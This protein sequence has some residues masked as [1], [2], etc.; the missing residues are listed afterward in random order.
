MSSV[1]AVESRYAWCR[2]IA[3]VLLMA[4]GGA[5]MYTASVV[6][7]VVQTEFGVSRADASLPY[8]ATLIAFALGGLFAGPLVDRFGV[9]RP[10]I[11]GGLFL[12]AG[13]VCA[14]LARSHFEFVLVHATL[15]GLLGSSVTW[16]PLVAD[17]SHW[18][19]R[20]RGI[21]VAICVSGSYVSGAFWPPVMQSLFDSIGWRAAYIGAGVVCAVAMLVLAA[22][23]LRRPPPVEAITP[24]AAARALVARPLGMSRSMLQTLVVVMG[25][26]CCIAMAMPQVH[27][28]AYCG[29]LGFGA[30]DG[31]QMLSLMLGFGIVSRL[32]AGFIADRVGALPTLLASSILQGIA[33]ILFVPVDGLGSLYT[34]SILF[35][36]FQG[37]IV[38]MYPLILR[39]YFPANEAGTRVSMALTATLLGMAAGGWLSGLIFDLTGSYRAAFVHGIA[40]NVLNIAIAAELLR[41]SIGLRRRLAY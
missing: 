4:L 35:G 33:L 32:A 18:F 14:G 23:M 36:L 7:P 12:G 28:V 2:L 29:D 26:S 38:P 37:G 1:A 20:R 11:G 39:D 17:I 30:R 19:R 24:E 3:S 13:L 21:A 5:G 15:I 8:T 22:T 34:V 16:G 31:A 40:W 41:R 9:M 27:I 10:V 6:I 25:V